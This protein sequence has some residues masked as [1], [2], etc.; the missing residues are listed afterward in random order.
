MVEVTIGYILIGILGFYLIRNIW[1]GSV[2]YPIAAHIANYIEVNSKK[3][4][5]VRNYY[6]FVLNPFW[7]HFISVF[8]DKR[9]RDLMKS[10]WKTV[11]EEIK[12]LK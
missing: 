3:K 5:P 1:V 8:K 9:D 11:G 10:V 2:L 12:N 7:W 4:L 6:L